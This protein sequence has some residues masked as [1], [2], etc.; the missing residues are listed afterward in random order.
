MKL[1]Q[2][3][4]DLL[5]DCLASVENTICKDENGKPF[6]NYENF[7]FNKVNKGTAKRIEK[8]RVKILRGE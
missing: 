5:W 3:E 8:L 6:A 4:R 7:F 2:A 1:T